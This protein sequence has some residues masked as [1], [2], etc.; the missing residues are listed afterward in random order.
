EEGSRQLVYAAVSG[1]DREEQMRGAY[2][3][4]SNIMEPSDS[5]ISR[6]GKVMQDKY[7]VCLSALNLLRCADPF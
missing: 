4:L 5:V 7:W 2:I 3:S 6:E 1:Q